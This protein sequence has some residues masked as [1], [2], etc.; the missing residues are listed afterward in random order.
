MKARNFIVGKEDEDDFAAAAAAKGKPLT[1]KE[2]RQIREKSPKKPATYSEYNA[3]TMDVAADPIVPY[4]TAGELERS[5]TRLREQMLA[6][7]KEMEFIEA[8]RMR[9]E[10]IKLEAKLEEMRK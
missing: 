4:M 10:I 2:K 6:A 5:I 7:A 8:A 9:D 1:A 3:E